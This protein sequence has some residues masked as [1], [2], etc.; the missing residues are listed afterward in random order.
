[1][2]WNL[3][4]SPWGIS[5]P[6][7]IENLAGAENEIE[8]GDKVRRS[9]PRPRGYLYLELPF[10]QDLL[11]RS[12]HINSYLLIEAILGPWIDL[13]NRILGI[14]ATLKLPS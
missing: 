9:H 4:Y 6:I 11:S 3:A 1:M 14:A 12:I 2:K 13:Y 10:M 5:A 7:S 8:N